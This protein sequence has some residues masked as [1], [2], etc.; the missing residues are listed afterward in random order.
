[1]KPQRTPC[2]T[3]ELTARLFDDWVARGFEA[4]DAY[5]RKQAAWDRY[6]KRYR[7]DR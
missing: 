6:C 2:T 1:M 7:R 5:L 4:L 3:S